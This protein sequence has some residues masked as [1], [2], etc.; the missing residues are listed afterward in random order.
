[1]KSSCAYS[2]G[3]KILQL[4]K[5]FGLKVPWL[6]TKKKSCNDKSLCFYFIKTIDQT[7]DVKEKK[8][9]ITKQHIL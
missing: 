3:I 2:L 4:F 7:S 5:L 9:Y 1:M 8:N 6:T